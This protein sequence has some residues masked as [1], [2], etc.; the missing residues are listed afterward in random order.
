MNE[1]CTTNEERSIPYEVLRRDDG[2]VA[3]SANISEVR[4]QP[5]AIAFDGKDAVVYSDLDGDAR[6]MVRL[7]NM[8][9]DAKD[10]FSRSGS[11]VFFEVTMD[12]RFI[13]NVLRI[14]SRVELP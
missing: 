5:A 11:A 2:A 12:G 9:V 6:Q 10:H 4:F 8:P 1:V 13:E 7:K 3:L 14:G